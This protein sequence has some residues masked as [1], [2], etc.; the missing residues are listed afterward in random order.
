MA[1]W[2]PSVALE[3]STSCAATGVQ[4]F[5]E[6]PEASLDEEDF[7]EL[8]DSALLLDSAP[9]LKDDE[10]ESFSELLD[11]TELLDSALLLDSAFSLMDDEDLALLLLDCASKLEGESSDSDSFASISS[12]WSSMSAT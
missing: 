8:L 2:A 5:S 6:P 4:T 1:F 7:T 11:S 3:S 9:S 12:I 10:E